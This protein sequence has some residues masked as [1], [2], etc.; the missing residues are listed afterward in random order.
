[1]QNESNKKS[2]YVSVNFEYVEIIKKNCVNKRFNF[3]ITNF[4][5]L[6]YEAILSTSFDIPKGD[7]FFLFPFSSLIFQSLSRFNKLLIELLIYRH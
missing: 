3:L 1:M 6:S 4:E 2:F 5:N 7:F